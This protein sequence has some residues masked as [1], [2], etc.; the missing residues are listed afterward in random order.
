MEERSLPRGSAGAGAILGCP[1]ADS[2]LEGSLDISELQGLWLV[3]AAHPDDEIIGCGGL[4]Q[5]H[6]AHAIVYLTEGAPKD[7]RLRGANAGLSR[8][9]YAALRRRETRACHALLGSSQEQLFWLDFPDQE[10]IFSLLEA[11]Q[12]V[13]AL[14]TTLRPQL[15]IGHAYEG[16]HPDHDAAAFIARASRRLAAELNPPPL[17]WEM[18][19]YHHAHGQLSVGRFLPHA[20]REWRCVLSP[21]ERQLKRRMLSAHASQAEVLE[22]FFACEEERFREAGPTDFGAAPHPGPLHYE[23]LGWPLRAATFCEQARAAEAHIRELTGAQR[24]GAA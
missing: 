18:T 14:L 23:R 22:P 17:L 15:V 20:G 10:L 11:A 24:L 4:L 6:P 1:E 13:A 19:S 2:A 8:S 7:R 21:S 3:I 12:R 9:A 5:R 16:G